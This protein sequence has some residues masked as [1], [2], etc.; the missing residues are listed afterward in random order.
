MSLWGIAAFLVLVFAPGAW[1]TFGLSLPDVPFWGRLFTGAVLSPAVVCVQFYALRLAGLPFGPTATALAVLN[2]PAVY[3]IWRAAPEHSVSRRG[4][5]VVALVTLALGVGVMAKPFLCTDMRIYSPHSW[6]YADPVY[7]FARGDL[8]PEDPVLAGLRLGYPVWSALVFQAVL[9]FLLDSAPVSSWVWT[10]LV[11]LL[12]ICGFIA[13]ITKELGGGRLA[14]ASAGICLLLGTNPVGYTLSKILPAL[15]D[16]RLFGDARYTPW[17]NKFYLFSTM[18][19]GLG[20]IA[21]L[22]YLLV[23]PGRG[24][25]LIPLC[26][27]LSGVGVLY[28]LLFPP[29]CGLLGARALVVLLESR[30]GPLHTGLPYRKLLPLLAALVVATVLTYAQ[31]QFLEHSRTVAAPSVLLSALGS[32]ARKVVVS[33]IA[34]SVLLLGVAFVFRQCWASNRSATATLLGGAL[35]S[36]LL[37]AV[38]FIPHWDNEYKFIVVISMCLAPFPALAVERI[39]R[40]WPPWRARL[41]V[42]VGGAFLLLTYVHRYYVGWEATADVEPR[43][44]DSS[45][46]Y[47]QLNPAHPWSAICTAVRRLTPPDTVLAIQNSDFYFPGLTARSLY[48]P[49][50]DRRYPG[51]TLRADVLAAEVRGYGRD[52]LAERRQVLADLFDGRDGDA[53]KEA[54]DRMLALG[55]P[56]AIVAEAQHAALLDWL[57]TGQRGSSVY[58]ND[59]VTVWLVPPSD[60]GGTSS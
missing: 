52:I 14:Q 19:L 18:P 32:G 56:V 7:M 43:L 20:L 49:P 44:V 38:F 28:P 41:A 40:Q 22:L 51:V 12:L 37:H 21:A 34:T 60:Q 13:A 15:A 36:Y 5:G 35:A 42:A 55:R 54:L 39:W 2:L 9:S 26:L 25:R 45:A 16:L 50:A 58:R 6:V 29:A 3:L 46:F 30:Q 1:V 47:L 31:V 23:H 53:R 17:V 11:W 27:L 48:V 4:V 59:G 10:N 24:A 8:V 33:I 57:K